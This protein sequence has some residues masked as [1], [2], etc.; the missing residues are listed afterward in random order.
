VSR[1]CPS[2]GFF[3]VL[4]GVGPI[5]EQQ[6]G[7]VQRS[8]PRPASREESAEDDPGDVGGMKRQKH[9]PPSLDKSPVPR[10]HSLEAKPR[11]GVYKGLL[12]GKAADY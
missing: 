5:T 6:R 12:S 4:N 9:R 3:D 11:Q 7:N 8:E 1:E 10:S 2:P